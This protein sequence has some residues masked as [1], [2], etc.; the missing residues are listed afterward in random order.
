MPTR[1]DAFN[2]GR[3]IFFFQTH[4]PAPLNFLFLEKTGYAEGM[5]RGR[6]K[7][8]CCGVVC[9]RGFG[10]GR[11]VGV[12]AFFFHLPQGEVCLTGALIVGERV[13]ALMIKGLIDLI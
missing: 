1:V 4:T 3:E 13:F 10:C 2:T 5:P 9:C 7:L 8:L 11:I 12:M 6:S